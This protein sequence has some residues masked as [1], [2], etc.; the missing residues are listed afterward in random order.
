[1]DRGLAFEE[2]PAVGLLDG[3]VP[4]AGRAVDDRRLGQQIRPLQK[5]RVG[6]GLMAG[7]RGEGGDRIHLA[8][9]AAADIGF[10]SRAVQ[11]LDRGGETVDDRVLVALNLAH[12]PAH[13]ALARGE[14]GPVR[15]DAPPEPDDAAQAGDRDTG[16]PV[17]PPAPR[18]T[19]CG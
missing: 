19:P 10:K 17:M 18:P 7:D 4:A 9:H 1:M 6:Q 13:P 3:L 11:R 14:P 8:E 5:P 16:A 2:Q 15:R 12:E